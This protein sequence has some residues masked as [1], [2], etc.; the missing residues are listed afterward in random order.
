MT[1]V[2]VV[3]DHI[4]S[5]YVVFLYILDSHFDVLSCT[6]EGHS[7]VLCV[8]DLSDDHFLSLR[9]DS[10]CMFFNDGAWFD[11][12]INEE[13]THLF[14]FIYYWDSERSHRFSLGKGNVVE[15]REKIGS[16]VPLNVVF[17]MDVLVL[18]WI[19]R[20][21]GDVVKP[22]VVFE[23]GADLFL[24]VPESFFLPVDGAHFGYYSDE[25]DDTK[26]FG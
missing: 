14:E 21:K 18:D 2:E 13:L 22:A 12:T 7:L 16:F 19:E 15:I 9:Q 23:E 4:S 8:E 26:C 24:N 6:G 17:G 5:G 20:D 25:L 11:F 3:A 1:V 10:D